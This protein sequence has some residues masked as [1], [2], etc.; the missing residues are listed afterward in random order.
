MRPFRCVKPNKMELAIVLCYFTRCAE[1]LH[2][3]DVYKVSR[4]RV[5]ITPYYS[6]QWKLQRPSKSASAFLP[7]RQLEPPTV[8]ENS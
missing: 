1:N 3:L 6:R 2:G 5:R 4:V 8:S 7:R